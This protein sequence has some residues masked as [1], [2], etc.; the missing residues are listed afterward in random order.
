MSS[1]VIQTSAWSNGGYSDDSSN[2]DYGTHDFIAEHALDWLPAQ[3]RQYI[4]NNLALYLYGTELPDNSRPQDG[5]GDTA[6]HHIYFD[7]D[8][9]LV[10]DSAAL[11]AHEEYGGT[12][13]YLNAGNFTMAAKTAGILSHY[14]VDM[15]VFGHVMGSNTVWG[16]E[17]HHSDYE[18]Y[19]NART[20]SY[21]DDFVIYLSFDG[22][23]DNVTAYKAALLLAFD[24]TF[25]VDGQLTCVWMDSNYDWSDQV[26]RDRCG[27][28]LNHAVNLLTDVLHTLYATSNQEPIE[29]TQSSISC[30]VTP[31]SIEIYS[32][33]TVSGA[34]DQAHAH[35]EVTLEYTSPSHSTIVR[36][37]SSDSEGKYYDQYSPTESGYWNVKASWAGDSSHY[38]ASSSTQS[39]IVEKRMTTISCSVTPSEIT[40]G[41]SLTISGGINPSFPD[42]TVILTYE[43]PDGSTLNR[44]TTT[45]F[46]GKYSEVYEP[47]DAGSWTVRASWN[48]DDTYY[49]AAASPQAFKVKQKSFFETPTGIAAISGG[50]V[51]IAVVIAIAIRRRKT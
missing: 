12:L 11:R 26:F 25:D 33:V 14:I 35:T 50:L 22:S 19:V 24:T 41:D 49:G 44:T 9:T 47:D 27:E 20:E 1:S 38:G 34:I 15:A 6:K 28:S 43:R 40:E 31:S 7:A 36:K 30:I 4:V 32:S 51:A 8:G 16:A 42:R 2:P 29:K 17:E 21:N 48:G 3:E 10:D 46:E 5:I 37:V 45:D 39:F 13:G 23:L 18:N